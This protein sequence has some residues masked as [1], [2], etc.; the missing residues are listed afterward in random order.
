MKISRLLLWTAPVLALVNACASAGQAVNGDTFLARKRLTR[1]LIARQ[2]WREAFFY[3]DQLHR[4][5]PKDAE[6]LVL[7][8]I[9]YREQGFTQEAETDLKE[10]LVRDSKQAEG[11]AALG[12]LYDATDRGVEAE[13]LHRRANELSPDNPAYLNNLGFSLFLRSKH[14]DAIKVYQ[15]ASR[16]DPTNRRIRTNLG[17]A[18]AASGDWPRAAYEFDKG[19]M[20][21]AQARNNLGFAYERKG[22]LATAYGLYIE[23]VHL[24][25]NCTQARANLVAVAAKL[26]RE[27]PADLPAGPDGKERNTP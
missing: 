21:P 14:S 19:G 4:E 12:M 8:G 25:P 3:A 10:A 15:Q 9:V 26:G 16:L 11:H 5:R 17:F 18:Y 27:L 24:D 20:T 1:E 6:V 2:D 23:A 22:D 7:R 13:K